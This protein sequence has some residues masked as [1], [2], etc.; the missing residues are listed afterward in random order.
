MPT[1]F[2]LR[3]WQRK[4]K[5]SSVCRASFFYH[6]SIK[7]GS[8]GLRKGM[9]MAGKKTDGSPQGFF[10]ARGTDSKNDR[11]KGTFGATIPVVLLHLSPVSRHPVFLSPSA[12]EGETAIGPD[13]LSSSQ[14]AKDRL[15]RKSTMPDIGDLLKN[16]LPLARLLDGHAMR[17]VSGDYLFF[18]RDF[19]RSFTISL[20]LNPKR[21]EIGHILVQEREGGALYSKDRP[22]IPKDIYDIADGLLRPVCLQTGLRSAKAADL[23]S[24]LMDME[25]IAVGNSPDG[26]ILLVAKQNGRPFARIARLDGKEE[27]RLAYRSLDLRRHT[28]AELLSLIEERKAEMEKGQLFLLDLNLLSTGEDMGENGASGRCPAGLDVVTGDWVAF[29]DKGRKCILSLYR[30]RSLVV[31]VR[32]RSVAL[33]E[34]EGALAKPVPL[35]DFDF[36][37]HPLTE[38][39]VV[40][41]GRKALFD[42]LGIREGAPDVRKVG[43]DR[44]T[45]VE[46]LEWKKSSR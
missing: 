16:R 42:A 17:L 29:V 14:T 37:S 5:E 33:L 10:D 11:W 25:G 35:K 30:V 8:L 32:K 13:R 44:P 22:E 39:T 36:L 12:V 45:V 41:K 2:H 43:K 38:P 26:E 15:E 31:P 46:C 3:R 4:R 40:L 6:S 9:P 27:V 23:L 18:L 19:D 24:R 28:V 7:K 21:H 1:F 20:T 34:G